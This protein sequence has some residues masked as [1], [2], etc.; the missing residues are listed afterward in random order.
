MKI[1]KN[2][3]LP[4]NKRGKWL[5]SLKDMEVGD[6]VLLKKEHEY[7]TDARNKKQGIIGAFRK[8][9][10]KFVSRNLKPFGEEEEIRLWRIE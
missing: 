10:W 1:E 8:Y 4:E 5:T 9:G 7:D 3:P 6:S 2:I